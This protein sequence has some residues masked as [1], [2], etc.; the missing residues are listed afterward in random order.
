VPSEVLK[1]TEQ[2][3]ALNVV[4]RWREGANERMISQKS[5]SI[6]F[7]AEG[8]ATIAPPHP[9]FSKKLAN[10]LFEL[11][12]ASEYLKKCSA[13]TLRHVYVKEP[14]LAN[15]L[16]TKQRESFLK[17][18][19]THEDFVAN[20]S[21][22]EVVRVYE[23]FRFGVEE[24]ALD[25]VGQWMQ[26]H[27]DIVPEITL[28]FFR[29]NRRPYWQLGQ[30]LG[31]QLPQ[32]VK[33][34]QDRYLVLEDG[35]CVLPA[36]YS[37]S[38]ATL[39][40]DR[41]HPPAIYVES[42][43]PETSEFDEWVK[44]LA[45]E[46]DNDKLAGDSRVNWLIARAQAAEAR[47]TMSAAGG[48]STSNFQSGL[49]W[50]SE[51]EVD[52]QDIQ[53]LIRVRQEE[54]AGLTAAKQFKQIE[55]ILAESEEFPGKVLADWKKTVESII[56]ARLDNRRARELFAR[57]AYSLTI[58]RRRQAAVENNNETELE[59]YDRLLGKTR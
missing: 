57:E 31:G 24:P 33:L 20:L 26:V 4:F 1:G 35:R 39:A 34:L 50:L 25:V 48:R 44:L 5:E 28:D 43:T 41:L 56:K 29:V 45:D 2:G 8:A 21:A 40:K 7:V 36:A 55:E 16:T 37:L 17:V 49:E 22:E 52:S 27:A 11:A 54:I 51:A 6:D 9:E 32:H 53:M 13:G 47:S 3:E 59:R 12:T 42:A 30:L 14:A 46:L 38:Y 58:E 23:H 18:L 19:S 15:S 10:R